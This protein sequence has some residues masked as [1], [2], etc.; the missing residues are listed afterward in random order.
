MSGNTRVALGI[1]LRLNHDTAA[2]L[3]AIPG[4]S[5]KVAERIVTYRKTHGSFSSLHELSNIK[6]IGPK[7]LSRLPP[8]LSIP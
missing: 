1:P 5:Q 4:L 8:Y 2:D 7:T 6:G 3:A